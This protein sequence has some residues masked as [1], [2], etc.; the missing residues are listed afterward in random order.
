LFIILHFIKSLTCL[1]TRFA[2]KNN[3]KCFFIE[4]CMTWKLRLLRKWIASSSLLTMNR[5]IPIDRKN[6]FHSN[7]TIFTKLSE[8]TSYFRLCAHQI[9]HWFLRYDHASSC[10]T[11]CVIKL[12]NV[13]KNTWNHATS[14]VHP[15]WVGSWLRVYSAL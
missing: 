5:W 4:I 6:T 9:H 11:V 3:V 15:N 14:L 2:W 1:R 13:N 10:L 7:L 8:F 12:K